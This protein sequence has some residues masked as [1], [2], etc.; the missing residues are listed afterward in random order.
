MSKFGP[1]L[2]DI[3]LG[4]DTFFDLNWWI[5]QFNV[6]ILS[7]LSNFWRGLAD[8]LIGNGQF[9]FWKS[10]FWLIMV[11]FLTEIRF[12]IYKWSILLFNIQI[13]S[14]IN[15]FFDRNWRIFLI[16]MVNYQFQLR[17]S[18]GIGRFFGRNWSNFELN[19]IYFAVWRPNFVCFDWY[20]DKNW[21]I[22]LSEIISISD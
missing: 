16:K 13:L 21:L 17:I 20:F 22:F 15:W 10:K 11:N 8:I 6:Q 9:F 1:E 2:V 12:F 18:P 4:V 14:D 3:L 7:E 5:L 19:M